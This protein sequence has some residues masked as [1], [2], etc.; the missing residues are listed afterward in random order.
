MIRLS[1]KKQWSCSTLIFDIAL[2]LIFP[3]FL[4]L[5]WPRAAIYVF[6]FLILCHTAIAICRYGYQREILWPIWADILAVL[7]G[8]FLIVF[9]FIDSPPIYMSIIWILTGLVLCYGHIRKI[10]WPDLP[11]YFSCK[12]PMKKRSKAIVF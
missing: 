1:E 8:I 4:G 3:T 9:A 6:I 12:K 11:Y 10:F 2:L 7:C 5:S